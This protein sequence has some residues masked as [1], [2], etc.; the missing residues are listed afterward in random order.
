MKA[1][2][3]DCAVS[4]ITLSAKN[5]DYIVSLVLDI[6][7]KQ[8]EAL[9][10][11][12]DYVLNRAELK[13]S[14][15]DYAAITIGP[16]SFTGLRLGL[17]AVKA[18]ELAY[19]IPVYGISSLKAY[20]YAFEDFNLPVVSAI[21]ARKERFYANISD[22]KTEVLGDG[23]HLIT[24]IADTIAAKAYKEVLLAGPDS[25]VLKAALSEKLPDVK[26][27]MTKVQPIA[28]ESLYKI[29]EDNIANNIPP[30]EDYDGPLYL[31][32]S[33]AEIKAKEGK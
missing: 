22:N 26:F 17:S 21:D 27:F 31:R 33:E 3:I 18:I 16:G 24:T 28:V 2:A 25:E 32:E 30:L 15:L 23:D 4:K 29:A 8:S 6:G 19:K 13:A 10:P 5:D 12:I 11:A 14:E 1:I 9:V 20:G 7:M